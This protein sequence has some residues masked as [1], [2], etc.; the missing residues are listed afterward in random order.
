MRDKD[1]GWKAITK[2]RLI[3]ILNTLPDDIMVSAMTLAN[4]GNLGLYQGTWPEEE[5][6]GFIDLFD[7]ELVVSQ[8]ETL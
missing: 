8:G 7:D 4:T 1:T 6:Y 5:Y 3:E 2:Q